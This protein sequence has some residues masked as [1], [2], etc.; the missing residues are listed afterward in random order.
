MRTSGFFFRAAAVRVP[1]CLSVWP[2]G[3][4]LVQS[5]AKDAGREAGLPRSPP[6]KCMCVCKTSLAVGRGRRRVGAAA[7]PQEWRGPVSW[8]Q[9][10]RPA[11]PGLREQP[12]RPRVRH[13]QSFRGLCSGPARL[14]HLLAWGS[15]L[16]SGPPLLSK[17]PP[18]PCTLP[19]GI[20]F[21]R[22]SLGSEVLAHPQ[23]TGP[24]I[25]AVVSSRSSFTAKLKTRS[26]LTAAL[27][28]PRSLTRAYWYSGP[29]V[30]HRSALESRGKACASASSTA[31]YYCSILLSVPSAR[32]RASDTAQFSLNRELKRSPSKQGSCWG[33]W[34]ALAGKHCPCRWG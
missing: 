26:V 16:W 17:S 32:N 14:L 3:Q 12:V 8:A 23:A 10:R 6:V 13:A 24:C 5:V 19:T 4:A 11:P 2:Q 21:S 18:Q 31:L 22:G 9:Q 27:G 33:R 25:F 30:A 29:E 1:F 28:S 20:G 34:A 15:P 7:V